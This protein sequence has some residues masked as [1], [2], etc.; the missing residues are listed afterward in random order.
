MTADTLEPAIN[1]FLTPEDGPMMFFIDGRAPGVG[2]E[3]TLQ[4]VPI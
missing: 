1:L 3:F 4:I 2:G